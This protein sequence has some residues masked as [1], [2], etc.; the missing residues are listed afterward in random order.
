MHGCQHKR[1]V[2]DDTIAALARVFAHVKS[3][4]MNMDV[5]SRGGMAANSSDVVWLL[6]LS[7]YIVTCANNV[8]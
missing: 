3:N 2:C 6:H 4:T 5:L 7:A 1:W 8:E